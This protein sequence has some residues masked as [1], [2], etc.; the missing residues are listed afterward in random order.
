MTIN[1][2]RSNL[3]YEI[4]KMNSYL[5]CFIAALVCLYLSAC[6]YRSMVV[7]EVAKMAE[8]GIS[9]FESDE[10]LALMKDAFP[11]NIKLME[12]L[13][14]NSPESEPMLILLAKLYGSYGFV[15]FEPQLEA[16]KM[17]GGYP[18]ELVDGSDG[19]SVHALKDKLNRY[20]LKGMAYALRAL[21][22]NHKNCRDRLKNGADAAAFFNLLTEKDVSALF[23]Y[24]FNL[25]EYVNLNLDSVKAISMAHLAEKAMM[26][27]AALDSGYFHG[28]AHLF[29]MAYY[30]SR[31]PMMG[32]DPK[33]ARMHYEKLKAISGDQF[34]LAEVY[35]ARYI[36]YQDQD[37]EGFEKKLSM[38]VETTV[39]E[40]KYAMLNQLAKNKAAIYLRAID[41]LF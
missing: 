5:K 41:E 20:F 27:V 22:V 11:A 8:T 4:E 40:K 19:L 35:Y 9:A 18:A 12:T 14:S 21:E 31:S 3:L 34:L 38:V 6:S 10:D 25:G 39:F 33:K 16:E 30:G 26:R 15:F 1:S 36:L 17:A 28:S 13:L 7:G 29:L 2:G 32:G 24:A 37:R 23:W